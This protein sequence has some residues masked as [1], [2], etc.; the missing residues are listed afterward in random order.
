MPVG[1]LI[2]EIQLPS[3][4]SLKDKRAVVRKLRDRI[5]ARF[6]VAV[7]EMDHQDVWQQTVLGFVSISSSQPVLESTL[8]QVLRESESILGYDVAGYSID[9]F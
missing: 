5:R 8:Q 9:Y 6:N 7:A 1:V 2:L 4:H 3:S